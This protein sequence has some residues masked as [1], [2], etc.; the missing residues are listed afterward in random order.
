VGD[1]LEVQVLKVDRERG[2]IG[3][4]RKRVLPN[5]WYDVVE[6]L[7]EGDLVEGTIRRI[8]SYGAFVEIGK[9]VQGLAHVS[10]MPGGQSCLAQLAGGS[11]LTVRVLRI[12]DARQRIALAIPDQADLETESLVQDT[13]HAPAEQE[14]WD[15]A[16]TLI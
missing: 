2:R 14:R 10:D 13:G 7:Y 12:D 1:E 15:P 6:N 3:L 16:P 8:V 9:G 4:S 5:P 11:Q